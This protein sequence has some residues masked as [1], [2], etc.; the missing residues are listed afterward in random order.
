MGYVACPRM[1][2]GLKA[3]L[4]TMILSSSQ[5]WSLNPRLKSLDLVVHLEFGEFGCDRTFWSMS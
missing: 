1:L 5:R 2:L 3:L 4:S